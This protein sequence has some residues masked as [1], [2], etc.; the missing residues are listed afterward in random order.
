MDNSKEIPAFEPRTSNL[1]PRNR[2]TSLDKQ[3][4]KNPEFEPRTSNHEPRKGLW[5][6]GLLFFIALGIELLYIKSYNV[7]YFISPDGLHYANIAE[8]FLQGQGLV[9]T[10]NFAQGD[11]GVV[12]AVAQKRDYVVGPVYPMLLAMVFG[13]FGF[14]SYGMVILVLHSVLGA[15]SAVFAYK[16]GELLF[17]KGYAWIPY[18]LTL[19]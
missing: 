9:N 1:E 13:V 4:K 16:T 8:N 19:G 14:K 10:A 18:G 17:G 7:G 2:W 15:A 5:I 11:D 6:T 12:R 3:D